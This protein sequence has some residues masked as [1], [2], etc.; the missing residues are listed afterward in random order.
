MVGSLARGP[1]S[2]WSRLTTAD[3]VV[4][5]VVAG[6]PGRDPVFSVSLSLELGGYGPHF[7]RISRRLWYASAWFRKE[8]QCEKLHRFSTSTQ[9]RSIDS[10]IQRL[11]WLTN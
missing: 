1:V 7:S 6:F 10:P 9:Q 3:Q 11:E 2:N 8:S 5:L 4:N